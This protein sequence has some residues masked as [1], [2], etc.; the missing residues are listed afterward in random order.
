MALD[1]RQQELLAQWVPHAKLTADLSWGLVDSTVLHMTVGEPEIIVKAGGAD[2]AHIARE[3]TAHQTAVPLLTERGWAP[4]LLHADCHARILVTTYIPGILIDSGPLES[5]PAVLRQAGEI[6]AVMHGS[7]SR[8]DTTIERNLIR[9]ALRWLDKPNGIEP[10][11]AERAR[12]VLSAYR[13]GPVTV[14]PSHGDY[15][16]RNW[17]QTRSGVAVIDYGRFGHRPARQDLLR[18]FFRRWHDYPAER[19]CFLE[20][21]GNT[22]ATEGNEWWIDVLREAVATAGW[23]HKVQDRTFEDIGLRFIEIALTELERA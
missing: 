8:I 19:E 5:D 23:A 20:G 12:A 7:D 16:G 13:P 15:S 17:L 9:A 14:V 11:S 22:S 10:I 21:Y 2:N 3:I 6:L 18:L 4:K 1:S